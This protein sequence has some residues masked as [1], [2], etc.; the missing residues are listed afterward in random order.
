MTL[1]CKTSDPKGFAREHRTALVEMHNEPKRK[2]DVT[3]YVDAIKNMLAFANMSM[4]D[5]MDVMAGMPFATW[6]GEFLTMA[7]LEHEGLVKP[8]WMPL[9]SSTA[10]QA[11]VKRPA[12]WP[13][14]VLLHDRY[15]QIIETGKQLVTKAAANPALIVLHAMGAREL[16]RPMG[17][18][19]DVPFV[20]LKKGELMPLKLPVEQFISEG[21]LFPRSSKK[22]TQGLLKVFTAPTF[23][24]D[25]KAPADLVKPQVLRVD[26]IKSALA[27]CQ[28]YLQFLEGR[29]PY[30][31]PPPAKVTKAVATE[32][33]PYHQVVIGKSEV[34]LTES[35]FCVATR[36]SAWVC[37][38]VPG[39]D[40]KKTL[41]LPPSLV[42]DLAAGARDIGLPVV[43]W[44]MIDTPDHSKDINVVKDFVDAKLGG[45]FLKAAPRAVVEWIEMVLQD[46]KLDPAVKN[47]LLRADQMIE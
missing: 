40:L 3:D 2:P 46:A 9:S 35:M 5:L 23:L 38:E 29:A 41:L 39:T 22:W 20:L 7:K 32:C 24:F 1:G 47:L 27:H 28:A 17:K 13:G 12:D 34:T 25:A 18:G 44:E 10:A 15:N 31:T 26:S 43:P 4:A 30:F 11:L 19:V 42:F 6:S 21:P 14:L 36:R 45:L 33:E 8:L 16:C 37:V